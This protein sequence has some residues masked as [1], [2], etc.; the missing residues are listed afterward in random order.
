MRTALVALVLP[1]TLSAQAD[2]SAHTP[3]FDFYVPLH[4][5]EDDPISG[6][7]GLWASGP[8]YKASFHDGLAFY[9]VR[10][11]DRGLAGR[12]SCQA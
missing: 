11:P 2:P 4:T 8:N 7:Y 9:P 10:G 6:P 12:S 5:S 1:L 3:Q